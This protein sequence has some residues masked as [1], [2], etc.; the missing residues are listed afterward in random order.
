MM[1]ILTGITILDFT[2]FLSGP[3]CTMMLSD[4]GAE[5]IKIERPNKELSAGPYLGGERTYDLSVM[6]GKKSVT[7][8]MKN[9]RQKGIFLELV[10]Q[11]DVIVE[12]FK[13]GTMAKMGISYEEIKE[14]NP[15]IVFTSISGYGQYG[16]L[17]SRGALDLVIQAG[18]GIMSVTGE[19]DRPPMKIGVSGSDL[20]TGL[21]AAIGT[22]AMLYHRARTGQG[23]HL[24]LAMMD[25]MMP[26]L[27]EQI[28]SYCATGQIPG[29]T[30]NTGSAEAPD[31]LF[32]TRDGALAVTARTEEQWN[33]LCHA[34][35]CRHLL[36]DPRFSDAKA[37]LENAAACSQALAEKMKQT[38]IAELKSLLQQC[39]VPCAEVRTIDQVV[40]D[41]QL[42]ARGMIAEVEHPTAGKYRLP[43]SPLRFSRT[44]G[45]AQGAAPILGADTRSVLRRAGCSEEE[46]NEILAEQA[47]MRKMFVDYPL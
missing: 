42:A 10:K 23:Q 14:V 41:E 26:C 11:A 1:G 13:P 29:R 33:A 12:N 6:R 3:T 24:D 19:P 32:E 20:F 31:D 28:I 2:Q 34:L 35:D 47:P 9:Q 8:D 46:I 15:S 37:R 36:E 43:N 40:G 4:M 22:L 39:G 27:G 18:S 25:A 5:V 21:Y 38:D 7:I 16:P 30:G 45:R 17:S 44:P